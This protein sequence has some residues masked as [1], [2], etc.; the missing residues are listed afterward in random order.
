MRPGREPA[1]RVEQGTS[2]GGT[3]QVPRTLGPGFFIQLSSRTRGTAAPA[4]ADISETR[5]QRSN[6]DKNKKSIPA[7]TRFAAYACSSGTSRHASGR[8]LCFARTQSNPTAGS[9]ECRQPWQA[10]EK[11]PFRQALGTHD[12]SRAVK[13]FTTS[14][15]STPA[16]RS[17]Q[18]GLVF[19][20]LPE[21]AL[22]AVEGTRRVERPLLRDLG[23]AILALTED[24][25][26]KAM[27]QLPPTRLCPAFRIADRPQR[28]GYLPVSVS[29]V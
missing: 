21:P 27:R 18:Q 7:G 5:V 15:S 8:L 11:T 9:G 20:T 23:T 24:V 28:T 2:P 19:C 10:S 26:L 12:F 29:H 22:S 13:V 16:A 3:A 17:Q 25:C 4:G 6:A 14:R 1:V